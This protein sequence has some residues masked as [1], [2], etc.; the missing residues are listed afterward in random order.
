MEEE[1]EELAT[2]A[3]NL[4]E[5]ATAMVTEVD[6]AVAMTEVRTTQIALLEAEGDTTMATEVD[7]AVVIPIVE[8]E[9]KD[10][11]PILPEVEETL[12]EVVEVVVHL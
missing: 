11:L 12:A 5:E 8:T 2:K 9:T 1:E 3:A 7:E 4:V 10:A 6:E